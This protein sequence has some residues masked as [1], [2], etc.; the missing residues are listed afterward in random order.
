[1]A[2]EKQ[3]TANFFRLVKVLVDL[4]SEALRDVMLQVL[5]PDTLATAVSSKMEK[6]DDL[7]KNRILFDKQYKLLTEVPPQPKKFDISLLTI[8]LR[9]LCRGV[10]APLS[11]W[12]EEPDQTDLSLGA[13]IV[14]LRNI[15]NDVTAHAAS[16]RVTDAVFENIWAK[17]T[18]VVVR[19]SE[20]GSPSLHNIPERI[21]AVKSENLDPLH[22]SSQMQMMLEIFCD[23]QKQDDR[24]QSIMEELEKQVQF[25][26][27]FI[28]FY[29]F[30]LIWYFNTSSINSEGLVDMVFIRHQ[31]VKASDPLIFRGR[32][33]GE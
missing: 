27:T 4:G 8:I 17:V 33:K 7:R 23:W 28:R 13:D 10:P 30:C 12:F 11:G 1:M 24:Y 2:D 19:I 31:S 14:R 25:Y 15:R 26:F 29:S 22:V 5:L 20:K 18:T 3:E 6:I 32:R 21:E 16:T 9:N